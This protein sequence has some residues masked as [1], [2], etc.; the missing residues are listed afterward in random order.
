MKR[1]YYFT[2]DDRFNPPDPVE[3][4]PE[5]DFT[6]TIELN[7][8][9]V[10]FVDN[11]GMWTYE[12]ETY[13][14]A[15]CSDT[16]DGSWYTDEYNIFIGDP[17]D[18]VEVVDELIETDMPAISG[19]YRITGHIVL[20]YNI[21]GVESKYDHFIDHNGDIDYDREVYTDDA[22][23]ELDDNKSSVTDFQFKELI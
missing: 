15:K 1:Y 7:L 23:V 14:W 12:D 18:I 20:C 4:T 21:S 9:A 11:H 3:L 10:V 6:E 22:E 13:G 19:K 17:E 5:D 8:D 2:E 16:S